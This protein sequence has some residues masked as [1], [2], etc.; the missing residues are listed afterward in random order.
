MTYHHALNQTD[1]S[2]AFT[3]IT[4]AIGVATWVFS[5]I[6]FQATWMYY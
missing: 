3:G 1:N 5:L 2:V 6:K 4:L